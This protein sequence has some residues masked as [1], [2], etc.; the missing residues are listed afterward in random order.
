MGWISNIFSNSGVNV[1]TSIGNVLDDL[2]TTDE[3][4]A[5]TDIQKKEN[6]RCL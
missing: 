4:L 3:E 6:Y 5:L 1:I 2:I